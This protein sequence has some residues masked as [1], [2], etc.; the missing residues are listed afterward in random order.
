MTHHPDRSKQALDK[1][2]DSLQHGS[3]SAGFLIMRPT[4]QLW[5][6]LAAFFVGF[7]VS[8]P[9]LATVAQGGETNSLTTNTKPA[10]GHSPPNA[11]EVAASYERAGRKRD[12]A[13]IYEEMARTNSAARKVLSHRLVTLY[14]ETGETN[15]ALRWARE[16]M[17]EN[18]DPQGYLAAVHARLG[19]WPEAQEILEHEIAGNTNAARAV[20]LRWQLAEV[21]ENVGDGTKATR[22][23]DQ[24]VVLAKGTA[25]ESAARDR[26]SV[27]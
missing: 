22:L 11:K 26:K 8:C 27:V 1:A 2:L 14:T 24:A 17:R 6:P 4:R 21:L 20:T 16:V 12:A 7:L 9:F 3:R 25:L 13:A 23:L 5:W 10:V 18:P 15:K 19:Q